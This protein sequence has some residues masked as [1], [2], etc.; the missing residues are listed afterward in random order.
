MASYIRHGDKAREMQLVPFKEY[1]K[2]A[3]RA[4]DI[5]RERGK[6][7]PGAKKTLVMG[8]ETPSVERGRAMDENK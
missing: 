3:E 4:W 1:I 2:A 7:S 8:T 6:L 5:W